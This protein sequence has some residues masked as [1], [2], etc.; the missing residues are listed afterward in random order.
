M[1]LRRLPRV[2][3]SAAASATA[4]PPALARTLQL[5]AACGFSSAA[6]GHRTAK[7]VA[8][9]VLG[10]LGTGG[11]L[12]AAQSDEVAKNARLAY[13]IPTRLARDVFTAASIVIGRQVCCSC[14]Q[15]TRV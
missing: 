4:G 13:L 7:R 1:A 15:N 9:T 12:W 8:L 10:V 5:P 3:L 14:L 2:L 11:V 6:A